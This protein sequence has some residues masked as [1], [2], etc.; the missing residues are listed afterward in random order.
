MYYCVLPNAFCEKALAFTEELRKTLSAVDSYCEWNLCYLLLS[1]HLEMTFSKTIFNRRFKPHPI[2]IWSELSSPAVD[3]CEAFSQWSK[4][5]A[6]RKKFSSCLRLHA[7]CL[8]S[9]WF[10]WLNISVRCY[11]SYSSAK[12]PRG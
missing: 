3:K 6:P 7:M 4:C 8:L 12:S 1:H 2:I 11:F 9:H 5:S 10:S